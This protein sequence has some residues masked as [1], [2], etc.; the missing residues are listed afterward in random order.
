MGNEAIAGQSGQHGCASG[1]DDMAA[2]HDDH[3][4]FFPP[5]GYHRT[6]NRLKFIRFQYGGQAFQKC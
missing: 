2:E 6:G 4:F 3:R 5:G 1:F